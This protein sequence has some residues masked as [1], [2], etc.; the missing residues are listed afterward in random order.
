[1]VDD[2]QPLLQPSTFTTSPQLD[3]YVIDTDFAG[4]LHS[5]YEALVTETVHTT[6]AAEIFTTLLASHFQGRM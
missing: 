6:E 5:V 2:S 4:M 1:M 3:W